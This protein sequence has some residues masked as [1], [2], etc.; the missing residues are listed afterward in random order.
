[1]IIKDLQQLNTEIS[2]LKSEWKNI[3]WTNWCFD[4]I[5]PWHIETFKQAK[6][7]WDIFIVG[8]NGD[9]S[10]YFASKPGRPINNE[11]FRSEMIDAIRYVDYIC[12]YNEETPY[13]PIT[14]IL[15]HILVK[16]WDYSIDNVVWWKEVVD[17]GWKI[18]I[19]PTVEGRST[20]NIVN[21]I[22]K[23]YG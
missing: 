15:T 22:L 17:N 6:A 7:L 9:Q 23:T 3:V 10:P 8:L 1:M 2:K 18:I 13:L 21:K 12:I 14:S 4:I 19:I 5:H 16:W 11:I 20:T